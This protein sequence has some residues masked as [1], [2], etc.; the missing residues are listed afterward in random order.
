MVNL[1]KLTI[2]S[3][4]ILLFMSLLGVLI[5]GVSSL[6]SFLN[7]GADRSKMLRA[8]VFQTRQYIP[9]ITWAPM[10][11][12]GRKMDEQTL[13]NIEKNYMDAWYIKH[14]SYHT[15]TIKGIEDYYTDSAE[16]NLFEFIEF[17]KKENIHIEETTL[18]HH[19]KINFFSEDG[20]LIS[21]TDYG[22]KEYKRVYKND[23]LL[24][25]KSEVS[26]YK[27]ILLLE[28]GFWRIRH[29]VKEP[30]QKKI[31]K[32]FKLEAYPNHKIK[33]INYYPQNSAWDTFGDNFD[34]EI[35]AK[36]F[37]IIKKANLNTIRIFI[38]Y[39]DFGKAELKPEKL[40]KLREL[41]DIAEHKDLK[42]IVTLF[43][44][45]G[46]YSV[47]DWTLTTQHAQTIVQEFKEHNAI[48]AWDVKNE[49]DLDFTS[50][51]KEKVIAWLHQTISTIKRIDQKHAITVGWAKIENATLLKDR[52]NLITFHYY[53]DIALFKEAY[54]KLKQQ[55][56]NKPIALGEY[57]VS[58]YRGI[59]KPF[60][61][62]ESTQEE[63]HKTMQGIFTENDVQFLSW[64][65]YDYKNIPTAVVGK[66]PWRKN[67]QKKF[68]F[69]DSRGKPK[70]SF[71]YIS[72]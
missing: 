39:E 7:T 67:A 5:F 56:P 19:P 21:L 2:R 29:L 57:G 13:R 10:T 50:R 58:S 49:P 3:L 34:K 66:L 20:Q 9:N 47:L 60:G 65:L 68:G 30:T 52:L 25:E 8:E 11:N 24:I 18:E 14:I 32:D 1:K 59:W 43:D 23:S 45:Y 6:F 72:N 36:D 69:I 12:V 61:S 38:Q 55:I 54:L 42:V 48:L 35:L 27:A 33:G 53:E 64:T 70:K 41:L 51:G 4:S 17:N 26:D 40:K 37:E 22:V 31:N 16:K 15:N 62:S 71:K 63:F 28:D 44:F 46:D